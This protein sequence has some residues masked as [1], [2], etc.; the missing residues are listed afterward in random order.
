MQHVGATCFD[1]CVCSFS[2]PHGEIFVSLIIQVNFNHKSRAIHGKLLWKNPT[3]QENHN[4]PKIHSKRRPAKEHTTRRTTIE[5]PYK[6][7]Q[8]PGY[9]PTKISRTTSTR[10]GKMGFAGDT[11]FDEGSNPIPRTTMLKKIRLYP[12]APG[13]RPKR[14]NRISKR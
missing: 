13:T 10:Q 5:R 7:L 4:R 12:R 14:D 2:I 9:H 1:V 11:Y 8:S 6:P 3:S